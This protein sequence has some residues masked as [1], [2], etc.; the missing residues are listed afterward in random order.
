[1]SAGAEWN[2][3]I[4]ERNDLRLQ[5][6]QWTVKAAGGKQTGEEGLFGEHHIGKIQRSFVIGKRTLSVYNAVVW[7]RKADP[8]GHFSAPDAREI[9]YTVYQRTGIVGR[10]IQRADSLDH[11]HMPGKRAFSRPGGLQIEC[12]QLVIGADSHGQADIAQVRSRT[13]EQ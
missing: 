10:S 12:V 6:T 11:T 2:D 9:Q 1:M 3:N 8:R 5:Q 13:K 7:F 4:V